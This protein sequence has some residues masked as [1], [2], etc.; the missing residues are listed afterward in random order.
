MH[1]H[2][3]DILT[4][5]VNASFCTFWNQN[6][7]NPVFSKF[8]E[9]SYTLC[10]PYLALQCSV[11][12]ANKSTFWSHLE[13][14]PS[15]W[16]KRQKPKILC[17][18][19][20][21]FWFLCLFCLVRKCLSRRNALHANEF[22]R[23]ITGRNSA[24]KTKRF[25]CIFAQTISIFVFVQND[26]I[27]TAESSAGL[28]ARHIRMLTIPLSI[29]YIYSHLPDLWVND[30]CIGFSSLSKIFSPRSFFRYGDTGDTCVDAQV[31][32]GDTGVADLSTRSTPE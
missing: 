8:R 9:N 1:L 16:K 15:L 7:K 6:S 24:W 17:S 27:F 14:D 30:P 10:N 2:S 32:T 18:N 13:F 12:A 3:S 29:N 25:A 20:F 4:S 5:Q 22:Y 11:R 28:I 19:N 26:R 23:N 21:H 31:D